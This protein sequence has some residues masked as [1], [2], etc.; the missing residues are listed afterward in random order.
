MKSALTSLALLVLSTAAQAQHEDIFYHEV[1]M[2]ESTHFA[3]KLI[4]TSDA[5][6]AVDLSGSIYEEHYGKRPGYRFVG[7]IMHNGRFWMGYV[8]RDQSDRTNFIREWFPLWGP[9]K[10]AHIMFLVYQKPEAPSLLVAEI[11]SLEDLEN[12]RFPESLEEPIELPEL[13]VSVEARWAEHEDSRLRRYQPQWG[14][15][16]GPFV[17]SAYVNSIQ[18]RSLQDKAAQSVIERRHHLQTLPLNISDIE[19]SRLLMTAIDFAQERGMR[20]RYNLIWSN[21]ANTAQHMLERAVPY[22][23]S[24]DWL[25]DKVFPLS[26][27][28]PPIFRFG[29]WRRGMLRDWQPGVPIELAPSFHRWLDDSGQLLTRQQLGDARNFSL[30]ACA[31]RL[32]MAAP[33]FRLPKYYRQNL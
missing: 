25:M 12:E 26:E 22:R 9:L 19:S 15:S 17:K 8:P 21:C 5:R 7:N 2:P 20:V 27:L 10:L 29:L 1:Q 33:G 31:R 13:V 24:W 16:L 14:L 4:D 6:G 32:E 28:F 18:I 30:G 3:G 11:P 23:N